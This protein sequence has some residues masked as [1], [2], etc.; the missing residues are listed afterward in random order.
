MAYILRDNNPRTLRDALRIAVTI[1][2]NRKASGLLGRRDDPKLF[3]PNS[4]EKEEVKPIKNKNLEEDK[5]DQM[6][7]LLK[8]MNPPTRNA[9][10]EITIDKSYFNNFSRQ[11]RM[12]NCP[13]TTH[14]KD[15][16]PI[17][18]S[19]KNTS[20]ENTHDP[21]QKASINMIDDYP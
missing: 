3:N 16:K 12:Q 13:Y 2:N 11:N 18:P 21:L 20:E 9:N 17:V 7:N 19:E 10:K 6:L 1:E 15:G 8:N 5:M 4:N 14:W